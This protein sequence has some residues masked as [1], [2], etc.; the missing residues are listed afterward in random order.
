MRFIFN[1]GEWNMEKKELEKK[2]LPLLEYQKLQIEETLG[3]D[4]KYFAGLELGHSPTKEEAAQH[5]VTHG[6]P[7]HFAETH[8]LKSRQEQIK[9]SEQEK[10]DGDKE[11]ER[12]KKI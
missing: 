1:K 2:S 3:D 10:C 4:N 9:K 5:Y 12:N 6:G 11:D 7:E 8:L